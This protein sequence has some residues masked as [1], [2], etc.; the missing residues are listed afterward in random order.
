MATTTVPNV[1]IREAVLDTLR[2]N[3][4]QPMQLL[5]QLGQLGYA[6]SDIRQA[7]SVLIREGNVELTSTR[8]LKIPAEPAA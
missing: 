2:Q 1:D 6:D 3:E 5:T 4:C 8:M 7:V